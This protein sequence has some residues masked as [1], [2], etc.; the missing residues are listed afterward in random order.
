MRSSEPEGHLSFEALDFA[1]RAGL[2]PFVVQEK[3]GKTY[4]KNWKILPLVSGDDHKTPW[5]SNTAGSIEFFL[6]NICENHR[7]LNCHAEL[8]PE[9]GT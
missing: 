2:V 4:G 5:V 9:D 8:T 6:V 1:A 7:S 3:H